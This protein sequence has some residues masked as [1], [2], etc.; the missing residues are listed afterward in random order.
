MSPV[1]HPHSPI[2][3]TCIDTANLRPLIIILVHSLLDFKFRSQPASQIFVLTFIQGSPDKPTDMQC[4]AASSLQ[5]LE[6]RHGALV[7][8]CL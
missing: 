6:Y 7:G 8:A 2:C 1:P 3:C 5:R 4:S